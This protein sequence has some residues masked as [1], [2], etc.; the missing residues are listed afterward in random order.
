VDTGVNEG[1]AITPYYDS[2]IAKLIV[3][4]E[5]RAQALARLDAALAGTHI[6][7]VVNNVG[8]L[9]RVAKTPSF[10]QA[11]LDTALIERERALLFGQPGLPLDVVAAGVVARATALQ[12]R[13]VD[14]DPWSRRDGWRL[15]GVSTQR[16]DLE[17]QGES[18]QVQLKSRHGGGSLLKVG[19]AEVAFAAR[20]LGGDRYDVTLGTHADTRRLAL[21][22]YQVGAQVSVFSEA[23]SA[24]ATVVDPLARA[25]EG[26]KEAGRLTAPMPGKVIAYLVKAGDAIKTGQPLAVLE[27]MKMEHTIA[28]PRDGTVAELLFAPGDQ[29]SEG[30]ELL[31][32][33]P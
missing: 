21:T 28:A 14:A 30:G 1:D 15:Q 29:V 11:H 24:Q 10:A 5:D 8:F 13:S 20:P 33:E 19:D 17:W 23:G 3:W 25:G 27:A 12:L 16:F 26:H 9:R 7:G 4:G 32:L 6:A 31:T 18:L 22:V 2:M